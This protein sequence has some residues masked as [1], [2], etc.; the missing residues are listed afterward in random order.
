MCVGE[1]GTAS[2]RLADEV[3]IMRILHDMLAVMNMILVCS[4]RLVVYVFFTRTR[5][6]K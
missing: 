4:C 3:G 2:V 1:F 5:I 6:V